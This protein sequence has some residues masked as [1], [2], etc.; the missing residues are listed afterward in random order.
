MC[1]K[2]SSKRCYI[3]L[4]SDTQSRT[5]THTLGLGTC[6]SFSSRVN[7]ILKACWC[8]VTSKVSPKRN[9]LIGC[10]PTVHTSESTSRVTR[11]YLVRREQE[12]IW[13]FFCWTQTIIWPGITYLFICKGLTV[14]LQRWSPSHAHIYSDAG[15]PRS[16]VTEAA[17]T[18]RM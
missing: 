10:R 13:I 7:S 15:S 14:R 12:E 16:Y 9:N 4:E 17:M 6:D 5:H 11:G 3:I 2:Y 18:Q 8:S 1:Y